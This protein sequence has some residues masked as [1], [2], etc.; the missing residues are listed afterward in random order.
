MQR[1]PF[2]VPM[3]GEG[4][5]VS[6]PP[7]GLESGSRP[8]GRGTA[9]ILAQRH[10]VS[11]ARPPPPARPQWSIVQGAALR[12][13]LQPGTGWFILSPPQAVGVV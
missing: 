5:H 8:D 1:T 11:R 9:T 6:Y 7:G 2:W 4:A 13:H 12:S 3:D 10:E